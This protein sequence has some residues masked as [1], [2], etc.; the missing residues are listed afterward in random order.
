MCIYLSEEYLYSP[1]FSYADWCPH[2]RAYI[3]VWRELINRF[4]ISPPKSPPTFASLS[5]SANPGLAA[6]LD[7]NRLPSFIVLD[8]GLLFGT[9]TSVTFEDLLD[10][11][12]TDWQTVKTKRKRLPKIAPKM[13]RLNMQ[14]FDFL[15]HTAIRTQEVIIDW[16]NRDKLVAYTF[17]IL[18]GAVTYFGCKRGY[19][20]I[21]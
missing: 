2:S 10:V 6:A 5:V 20:D 8:N 11:A 13:G 21:I 1:L 3:Q 16:I 15:S 19:L 14:A 12:S 7:V 17:F 18:I 9:V 4:K